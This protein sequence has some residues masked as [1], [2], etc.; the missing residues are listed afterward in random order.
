MHANRGREQRFTRRN[1]EG[2]EKRKVK[3]RLADGIS[4]LSLEL[5][6]EIELAEARGGGG[7][8]RDDEAGA[9]GAE[10]AVEAI[11]GGYAVYCGANSPLRRRWGW[12]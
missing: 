11:A 6:R 7:V 2:T 12:D 5:A 3:R 10:A 8:R 1:T 9:E 4:L